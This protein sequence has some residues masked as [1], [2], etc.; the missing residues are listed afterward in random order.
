MKLVVVESP[1][2]ARTIERYLGEDYSV[3]ATIGH[4]MDLPKSKLGVDVEK[5]FLPQYEI[6]P[7][8]DKTVRDLKK[9][10]PRS[11]KDVY[12]ALDPDREG[13]AIA[14]H[15]AEVL[16]LKKPRRVVFHEVTKQAILEAIEKSG[17]KEGMYKLG[18]PGPEFAAGSE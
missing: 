13:E 5:N 4:V 14:A 16:K 8:K 11:E 1:A 2:K 9:K 15:V 18:Q 7:G 17:L 10:V 12:L 3:M 6:M